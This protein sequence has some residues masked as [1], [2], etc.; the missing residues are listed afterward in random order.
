MPRFLPD[1][2]MAAF[3]AMCCQW[4]FADSRAPQQAT[5]RGVTPVVSESWL[6]HLHRAFNETN[7]GKTYQLGPRALMPGEEAV[8]W[9]LQLPT[10]ATIHSTGLRGSDLYRLNCQGCH[11]DSGS[12]APPEIASIIDPVRATS[13]R[14][15]VV[16]MKNAGMDISRTSAA[17]L[18][19]QAEQALIQRLH[20]GGQDMPA[21]GH[22]D[23]AE[24]DSLVAYLN[25]LADVPLEK[26]GEGI[27][28]ETPVRVGELIVKSTCHICHDATGPNPN[29]EQLEYGVIPPLGTLTGRTT[30]AEFVRKVTVGAPLLAGN[31]P[32]LRGGR[33]P[34]FRYLS[35][36]EAAA[37]YLYLT[38]YPPSENGMGNLDHTLRQ[39]TQ[40]LAGALLPSSLTVNSSSLPKTADPFEAK[41]KGDWVTLLMLATIGFAVCLVAGGFLLTMAVFTRLS[42]GSERR[43][44]RKESI[45]MPA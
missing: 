16:R 24:V 36:N 34:V 20:S 15:V 2:A 22:L 1:F 45:T 37:V 29:P 11:R 35:Q 26:G 19:K 13:A 3:L 39:P 30:L 10:D 7:M 27:V 14:L 4:A 42:S 43:A 8:E 31:P 44:K 41:P 18:A 23:T 9:R 25:E 40:N 32:M 12:G 21:F 28:L 33:M 38:L 17:E 5:D 6:S